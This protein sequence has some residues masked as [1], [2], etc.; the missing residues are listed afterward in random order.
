[1]D[2]SRLIKTDSQVSTGGSNVILPIHEK[3]GM[4]MRKV[5]TGGKWANDWRND[6]KSEKNKEWNCATYQPAGLAHVS[7][8]WWVLDWASSI[9]PG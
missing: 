1:M 5:E 8:S 2:V 4:I 7:E 9:N 6:R 3:K